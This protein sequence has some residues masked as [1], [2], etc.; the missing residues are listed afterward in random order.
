MAISQ[1]YR[2]EQFHHKLYTL[3]SRAGDLP[4]GTEC[5]GKP[6]SRE[7]IPAGL[8]GP[9]AQIYTPAAVRARLVIRLTI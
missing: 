5:F 9:R 4:R 8:E 1:A 2:P 6:I 3:T 7:D